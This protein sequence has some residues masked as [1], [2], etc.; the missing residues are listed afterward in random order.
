MAQLKAGSTVDGNE[1]A[2][3][4]PRVTQSIA[5]AATIT[6]NADTMKKFHVTALAVNAAIAA[7]EGT[8]FDGQQILLRIRDNGSTRTLTWNAIYRVISTVLPTATV[9][10]KDVYVGIQYNALA[11]K[12]DVLAVG[13]E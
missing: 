10:G 3:V 4:D 13:Q 2:T 9:A 8:P 6:P 7:P 1:I 11:T 12:W 5:S